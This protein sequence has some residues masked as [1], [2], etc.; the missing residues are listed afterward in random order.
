M[1]H[2]TIELLFF[3]LHFEQIKSGKVESE[4]EID[5]AILW[6]LARMG[7]DGV[8]DPELM[9]IINRI[10]SPLCDNYP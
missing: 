8:I 7:K 4:E 3:K 10:V 5:R 2:T 1:L 9:K 6:K